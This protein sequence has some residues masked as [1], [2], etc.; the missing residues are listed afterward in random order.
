MPSLLTTILQTGSTLVLDASTGQ[1][2]CQSTAEEVVVCAPPDRL[3][4]ILPMTIAGT[5]GTVLVEPSGPRYLACNLD[6][7]LRA[8][9]IGEGPYSLGRVGPVETMGARAELPVQV[10]DKKFSRMLQWNQY[11]AVR[12]ADCV[13]GPRAMRY[14]T[15]VF[16]LS[17]DRTDAVD[18]VLP[19]DRY[20]SGRIYVTLPVGRAT[21]PTRIELAYAGSVVTAPAA[22][23][24]APILGGTVTGPPREEVIIDGIVRPTRTIELL[25]PLRIGPVALSSL[26]V[27]VADYGRADKLQ[28]LAPNELDATDETVVVRAKPEAPGA[29]RL[30]RVG[31]E[32]LAG[33]VSITVDMRKRVMTLRC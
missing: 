3:T 12:G 24:I 19:F 15:V 25:Q 33:C 31:R 11:R 2:P 20:D 13:I 7:I 8:K 27:R 28:T 18:T 4:T 22:R 6:F 9:I 16:T 1:R 32:A 10:L 17:R 26:S 23:L 5:E 29:V 14:R 21:L 30:L